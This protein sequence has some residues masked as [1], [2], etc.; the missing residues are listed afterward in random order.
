MR[1]RKQKTSDVP[2]RRTVQRDEH[3]DDMRQMSRG[4]SLFRRGRTLTGSSSATVGSANEL[5]GDLRSPR[6]HVHHLMSHRR[7]LG[8]MFVIAFSVLLVLSWLLFEFT[9]R[10]YPV[11]STA[12]VSLQQDR[13]QQILD[14]YFSSHPIERLRILVNHDELSA[15]VRSRAPEVSSVTPDGSAGFATSR[16]V[17][18]MRKPLA[19]WSIGTDRHYVDSTGVVFKVNYFD[20]PKLKIIDESGIPQQSGVAAVSSRFLSFVG[21]AVVAA[22]DYQLTL[23]EAI[24]PQATT[25]QLEIKVDGRGYPIK[26]SLDRPVGEQI[27]DAWY[28]IT[29]FDKKGTTPQYVDV[30][31]SGKAFYK[32]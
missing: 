3:D 25:R 1:W 5:G 7:R 20:E 30:R 15:Y 19:G 23:T 22:R 18:V 10:T 26:L 17:M 11:A 21:Y 6:A 32:E 8:T 14:D 29:Y 24:I 12:S 13:Y 31:V 28:A 16:F 27:E 4:T 9:A 2:R